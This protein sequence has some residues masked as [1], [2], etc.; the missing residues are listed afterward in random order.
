[1]IEF[2][3]ELDSEVDN[4]LDL[5]VRLTGVE[6]E[7]DSGVD[8]ELVLCRNQLIISSFRVLIRGITEA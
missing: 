4:E 8:S 3:V 6:N 2:D 1:M 7:H 5:T